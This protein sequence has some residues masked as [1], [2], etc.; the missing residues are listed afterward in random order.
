MAGRAWPRPT[1]IGKRATISASAATHAR[2]KD[3]RNLRLTNFRGGHGTRQNGFGLL[4]PARTGL[5]IEGWARQPGA[6]GHG[7]MPAV[8]RSPSARAATQLV[9][10]RLGRRGLRTA[11]D[12]ANFDQTELTLLES[13]SACLV[14]TIS[15]GVAP[16]RM[17]LV[18]RL[19]RLDD[20]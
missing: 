19:K 12:D 6:G 17:P 16:L 14:N 4:L 5:D 18:R 15:Y 1:K 11:R 2:A 10:P 9:L 20:L 8:P 3:A 7:A 13:P